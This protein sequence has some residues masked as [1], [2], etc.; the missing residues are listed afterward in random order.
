MWLDLTLAELDRIVLGLSMLATEADRQLHRDLAIRLRNETNLPT[1]AVDSLL[2]LE[3]C[4]GV[5][6]F[7][8]H[9]GE[10]GRA[11][12]QEIRQ[13]RPRAVTVAPAKQPIRSR[14]VGTSSGGL[15][16]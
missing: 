6:T 4:N 16:P 10:H 15:R 2:I 7:V 8:E 11:L 14:R 13:L 3:R 9:Y 5:E 12:A 1:P